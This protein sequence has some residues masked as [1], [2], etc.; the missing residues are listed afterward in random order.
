MIGIK[1]IYG[2]KL[3]FKLQIEEW[4]TNKMAQ[5]MIHIIEGMDTLFLFLDFFN[6]QT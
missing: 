4:K 2:L 5:N 3:L 6:A 1:K